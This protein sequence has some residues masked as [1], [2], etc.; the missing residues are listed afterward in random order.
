[1]N[2]QTFSFGN[3]ELQ[4]VIQDDDAWFSVVAVAKILGYKNPALMA[5]SNCDAK[6]IK[7]IC[8]GSWPGRVPLF[9]S[10]AGLYQ[11]IMRSNKESAG[12][13]QHWVF[14][15]VLPSIRRTG[16]YKGQMPL[17]ELGELFNN[18]PDLIATKPIPTKFKI[19]QVVTVSGGRKCKIIDILGTWVSVKFVDAQDETDIVHLDSLTEISEVEA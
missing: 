11:L 12:A 5:R 9:V 6:H 4:A 19:R 15:E 16:S 3:R 13:F 7:E 2:Y 8:L 18:L 14:E 17:G 10:E 1:M